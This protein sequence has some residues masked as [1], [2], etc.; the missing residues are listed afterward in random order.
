MF[1]TRSD[2]SNRQ[3]RP[4]CKAHIRFVSFGGIF[5]AGFLRGFLFIEEE[6]SSIEF[7]S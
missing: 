4:L 6:D 5:L 3:G 7:P 2:R 1:P